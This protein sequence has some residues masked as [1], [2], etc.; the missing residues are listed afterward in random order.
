MTL[1]TVGKRSFF[2]PTQHIKI[3]I[4]LV[5]SGVDNLLIALFKALA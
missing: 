4:T 1:T 3:I 5:L 2:P